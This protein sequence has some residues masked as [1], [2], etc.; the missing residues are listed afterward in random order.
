[1]RRAFLL[2]TLGLA[3]VTFVSGRSRAAASNP[4]DTPLDRESLPGVWHMLA[5]SDDEVNLP[6]HRMDLRFRNA[7]GE[8][9]GVILSRNNGKEISLAYSEFDGSTLRFKLVAPPD[10]APTELPTMVMVWTGARFE[11]F[12]TSGTGQTSGP[13]LKLV[14]SSAQ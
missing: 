12:W 7:S 13:K 5:I 2:R 9:K 14:R 8:L 11:G 1:M 4:A 10:Q 6:Q 3:G